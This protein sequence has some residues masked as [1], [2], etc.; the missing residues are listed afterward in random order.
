MRVDA[1]LFELFYIL[2]CLI[3]FGVV[4]GLTVVLGVIL[5]FFVYFGLLL[6]WV[7]YVVVD[8]SLLLLICCY[9][10]VGL[11]IFCFL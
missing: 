8:F 9:A 11:F 5:G 1:L 6:G 7:A 4:V 10:G 2:V 3:W